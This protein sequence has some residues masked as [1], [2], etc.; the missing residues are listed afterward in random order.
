MAIESWCETAGEIGTVTIGY[1]ENKNRNGV[2][3]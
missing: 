1:S 2:D 3:E